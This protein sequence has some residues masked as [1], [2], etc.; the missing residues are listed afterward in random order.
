MRKLVIGHGTALALVS[1]YFA[2]S[3]CCERV[4]L[5]AAVGLAEPGCLGVA[6]YRSIFTVT[7]LVFLGLAIGAAMWGRE[8][9]G[10][11]WLGTAGLSLV[12][13]LTGLLLFVIP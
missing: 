1:A 12:A 2:T 5:L 13:S 4:N 11:G 7:S 8:G 6:P 9:R 3:H 10:P